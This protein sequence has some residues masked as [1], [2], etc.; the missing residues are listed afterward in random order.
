[1]SSEV[2]MK[3]INQLIKGI[4]FASIKGLENELIVQYRAHN[5]PNWNNDP[6]VLEMREMQKKLLSGISFSIDPGS[7][8]ADIL[9]LNRQAVRI[10]LDLWE[11][12]C[13]YTM[14]EQKPEGRPDF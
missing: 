7:R 10:P 13:G 5:H 4:V 11:E 9:A 1:M 2:N 3:L 12:H 14:N 6:R 8:T